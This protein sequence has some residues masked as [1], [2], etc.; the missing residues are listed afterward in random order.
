[1]DAVDLF[2]DG[3][4]DDICVADVENCWLGEIHQFLVCVILIVFV[5]HLMCVLHIYNARELSCG[6]NKCFVDWPSLPI[7]CLRM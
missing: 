2:A 1:M 6:A 4:V 3:D 5:L 7:V